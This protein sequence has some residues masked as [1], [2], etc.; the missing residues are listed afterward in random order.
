MANQMKKVLVTGGAGFIGS[1]LSTALVAEGCAVIVLDNL[2]S[3][4]LSNLDEIKDHISFLQGDIRDQETVKKAAHGCDAIFHL[5]AVV[6]VPQTIRRPVDSAWINELGTL[7]VLETAR[8]KN[9]ERVV[10][11]SSSAVYGDDPQLPKHED[12]KPRP[13][14]PYAVQKLSGEYYGRLYSDL[15]GIQTTCLR[16][17]NI[18]GPKQDPSSPYS[19]VI[20]I[21]M[22][23]AVLKMPPVIYGDGQQTRDFLYVKDVVKALILAGRSTNGGKAVLNV[24]SGNFITIKQL[25]EMISRLSDYT[26]EA[27]YQQLRPGDILKSVASIE[28]VKSTLGF[29]PD[30]SLEE[31]LEIT[32]DWYRK[33]NDSGG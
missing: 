10:F 9:V 16:L 18:F 3:G 2:S 25:W 24:G 27:Q 26:A 33:Y 21:F 8:Q 14:S 23:Q 5:A 22:T 11:A 15:Y 12:M 6:S 7:I 28:R 30:L 31:G 4:R 20:S 32:L 1:H 17:F 19:G 13:R 29:E